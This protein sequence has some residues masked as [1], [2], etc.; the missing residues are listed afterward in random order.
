MALVY[1]WRAA[2][3]YEV[4]VRSF[5]DT[6]GDGVGDLAGVTASLNYL[7]E[8]G[9]SAVWLSPIHPSPGVDPGYD[10]ADYTAVDPDL[11]SLADLDELIAGAHR[12]GMA[13]LLDWVVNHTSNRHPW[14]ADAISSPSSQ[15]RDWYLFRPGPTAQQ[16]ARDIRW[17]RLAA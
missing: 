4:Y 6:D 3:I 7:S 2:V 5:R 9:V 10:V 8:L 15:H 1:D 16:L 14:F 11:G 17:V 12:R 13:V